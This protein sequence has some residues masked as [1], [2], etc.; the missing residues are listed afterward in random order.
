MEKWGCNRLGKELGDRWLVST[1]VVDSIT[2]LT[3]TS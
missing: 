1:D 3:K 2:K